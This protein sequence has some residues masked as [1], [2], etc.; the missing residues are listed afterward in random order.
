MAYDTMPWPE[1]GATPDMAYLKH[2]VGYL[3]SKDSSQNR[4]AA[5]P[6]TRIVWNGATDEDHEKAG[7]KD[8]PFAKGTCSVHVTR[9]QVWWSPSVT[10][11]G[12][13]GELFDNSGAAINGCKTGYVALND[14]ENF[15]IKCETLGYDLIASEA[16]ANTLE[17]KI[18]VQA[19]STVASA[20]DEKCDVQVIQDGADAVSHGTFF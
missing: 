4:N 18:G 19:W 12:W 16:S 20:H 8:A 13:E 3:Q 6:D 17:F 14:D 9:T 10:T 11:R 15:V 7:T 5:E 1:P 2:I